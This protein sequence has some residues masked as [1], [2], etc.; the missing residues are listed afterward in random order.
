VAHRFDKH[1]TI[2]LPPEFVDQPVTCELAQTKVNSDFQQ[3]PLHVKVA[4]ATPVFGIY[5]RYC[6]CTDEREDPTVKVH[7]PH[8]TH[9]LPPPSLCQ[10]LIHPHA[11]T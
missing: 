7:T 10:A 6:V 2:V 9:T 4:N 8:N 11:H 1:D 3:V 5:I